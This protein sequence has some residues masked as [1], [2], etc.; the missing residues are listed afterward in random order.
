MKIHFWKKGFTLIELMIVIAIIGILAVTIVPQLTWAQSRARDTGRIANI[1]TSRAVLE[2]YFSDQWSYP[3]NPKDGWTT[4]WTCLSD[5][6][7]VMSDANLAEL[8]KNS[9][10]PL[11]P[12]RTNE[13]KPCSVWWAL[14]YKP[15]VKNWTDNASYIITTNVETDNKANT[16]YASVDDTSYETAETT[17]WK[18]AKDNTAS[19]PDSIYAEI[20]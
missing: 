20:Y 13:S 17:V 19:W 5:D 9:K 15:L 8:F 7:W 12:Q 1:A 2:T 14:W 11:D 18:Y 4:P 10:A 16:N 3:V 6:K